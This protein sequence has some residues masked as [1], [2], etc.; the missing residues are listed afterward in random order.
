MKGTLLSFAPTNQ[1]TLLQGE[2]A[3]TDYQFN[4]HLIHHLFC[5]TCGVTSFARG[6]APTGQEMIA[7]NVRCL[8]KIDIDNLEIMSYDG[9]S[10]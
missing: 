5:S 9:R 4:K 2:D 6:V 7:I 8:D 10:K 3:L 1:F